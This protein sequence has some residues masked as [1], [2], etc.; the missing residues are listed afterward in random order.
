MTSQKTAF[1]TGAAKRIGRAIAIDLGQQGWA[2]GVHYNSSDDE[3]LQVCREIEA[4]GGQAVPVKADL[5]AE[6]EERNLIAEAAAQLGPVSLLINNAALFE[7]DDVSSVSR[8]S[9]DAH[10]ETNL[11]APFNLIQQF[12]TALPTG[13]QGCVINMLDQRVWNLT[14]HFVSYTLSK[15][16]LWTLTQTLALSLAPR[17]RVNAIGPGPSLPS[18]RQTAEQFARQRERVPLK[19]GPSTDEICATIRYL[20]GASSVTGQMIALDG[21]QHMGW[22]QPAGNEVM[23]E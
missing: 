7:Y 12:A 2:V 23:D 13:L 18:A 10:M 8:D 11:R 1:V 6:T 17:I 9:W 19:T 21:G 16:G 15:S 22:A 20:A 3:A 4:A 5:A 14:P